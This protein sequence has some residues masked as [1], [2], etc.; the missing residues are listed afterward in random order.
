MDSGIQPFASPPRTG[1]EVAV[2]AQIDIIKVA[3]KRSSRI[4]PDGSFAS[5]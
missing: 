4:Y 1:S 5:V 3:G 2:P